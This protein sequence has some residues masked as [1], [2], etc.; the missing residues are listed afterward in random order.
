MEGE[1]IKT[2]LAKLK[3]LS[4]HYQFGKQLEIHIRD[5]FVWGLANEKIRRKLLEEHQLTYAKTVEISTSMEMAVCEAA[6][7]RKMANSRKSE[8]NFIRKRKW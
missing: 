6:D 1:D 7:M 2:Y 8:L 5:Q 3:K 4:I